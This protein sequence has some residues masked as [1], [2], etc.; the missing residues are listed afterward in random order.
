VSAVTISANDGILSR[1]D[2]EDNGD[3]SFRAPY[4]RPVIDAA[5]MVSWEA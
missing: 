4:L 2:A 5:R 1:N 3:C